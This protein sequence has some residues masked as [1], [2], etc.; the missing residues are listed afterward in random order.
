MRFTSLDAYVTGLQ[1]IL[2]TPL[3]FFSHR[4][5]RWK[6]IILATIF[7]TLFFL[8]F[9]PFG[10]INPSGGSLQ[11]IVLS[12]YGIVSGVMAFLFFIA[13][14]SIHQ[15]FFTSLNV[16]KAILYFLLFFLLLSSANYI[17]KTSWCGIGHYT[18]C[19]FLIVFKRT[20]LI[21]VLPLILL[22]V[23]EQ[24]TVLKAHL[25]VNEQPSNQHQEWVIYSE[26]RKELVQLSYENLLY[27]E[28]A[29]NYV[30]V[31]FKQ[32]N[33]LEKKLLRTTLSKV[34][35]EIET[36]SIVRCHRSFIINLQRVTYASGNSRGL[37]LELQDNQRKIPVSR[38]YV[39]LISE[40]LNLA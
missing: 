17:Y 1:K 14:P 2:S 27:I 19:G 34:E 20:L 37:L 4:E 36:S 25:K 23:W 40:K 8:I 10:L 38:R 5:L 32:N 33:V 18:W 26:N 7:P 28:S 31:Y 16:G 6:H 12:G 15:R 29:D 9:K 3:S 24:N 30:E 39:P 11:Y 13:L 35:Q 22:V 21:G